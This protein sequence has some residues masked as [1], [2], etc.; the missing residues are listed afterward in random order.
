M[1]E[2]PRLKKRI[3]LYQKYLSERD[4]NYL[5]WAIDA[6]VYWG[7]KEPTEAVLHIHG[8]GDLVFPAKNLADPVHFI[9][10]G[11]AIILTQATW[12][13]THLPKLLGEKK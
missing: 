2:G 4:P 9:S 13:N 10:G 1:L 7:Q 3:S 6:L 11:H 12:F 8:H 5:R